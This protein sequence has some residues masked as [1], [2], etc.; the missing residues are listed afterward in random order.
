M[1][2]GLQIFVACGMESV[3]P[4]PKEGYTGG[5]GDIMPVGNANAFPGTRFGWFY[6]RPVSLLSRRNVPLLALLNAG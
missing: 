4:V 1:S 5:M 6:P 3:G 2:S